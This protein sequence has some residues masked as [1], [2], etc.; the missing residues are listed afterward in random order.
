MSLIRSF[1][2]VVICL[3]LV[4]CGVTG[5]PY[6]GGSPPSPVYKVGKPYKVS[7]KVYRPAAD[8]Y[9]D[10]IGLA[11]WYGSKF[12]GRKTANGDVFNMNDLTAAHTTLPMP[13]YVRVTNMDNG[14]WLILQVNDRGPFVGNRLIDVSR[15]AAQL[16]GFEKK[17][18]TKVRVQA[19][20][21]PRGE[22]PVPT[23]AM[24]PSQEMPKVQREEI[25]IVEL[26]PEKNTAPEPIVSA[27]NIYVQIGAYSKENNAQKIAD[28][29]GHISNTK[30]EKVDVNGQNLYRVRVGPHPTVELAEIILGR[31]LSLGHNTA[32]IITDY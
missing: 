19:V 8:P 17:G 13:S 18:V 2:I 12:H 26:E 24:A 5:G 9:Y 11:S 29:M 10:K 1:I 15:R 28:S 31:I 4:A 22:L 32:R 7:G 16:L 27:K 6:E 14:R 3:G 20:K 30:I 21:G 25:V 23:Q